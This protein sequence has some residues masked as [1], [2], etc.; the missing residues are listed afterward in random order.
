MQDA[1][2]DRPDAPEEAP[3]GPAR[4]AASREA[5]DAWSVV[6]YL[7]SGLVVWGGA[8]WLV[9]LW[10]HSRVPI[11]IGIIFGMTAALYLVWVRYGRA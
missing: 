1:D 10:V 8:G 5:D 7:L 4:T 2:P 6:S 9:G 3:R 11:G